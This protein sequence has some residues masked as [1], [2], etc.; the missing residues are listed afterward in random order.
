MQKIAASGNWKLAS[1]LL[2]N[3]LERE[4]F[5]KFKKPPSPFV[6]L[7]EIFDE[8]AKLTVFIM[9]LHP[10]VPS[11]EV[12]AGGIYFYDVAEGL[13]AMYV[14]GEFDVRRM[15]IARRRGKVGLK[16]VLKLLEEVGIVRGGML[17]G[18]GQMAAKSLLCYVARRGLY[19]ESI[20]LSVLIVHALFAEMRNFNGPGRAALMEAVARHKRLTDAVREWLRASPKL[21]HRDLPLFYEWEDAIKDFAITYAEKEEEFRFSV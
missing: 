18:L 20:Y 16:E 13:M 12:L 9:S 11:S 5:K 3:L 7:E 10:P 2:H 6:P 15:P 21:Y 19:M 14:F 17:T 1:E 8:V 4:E